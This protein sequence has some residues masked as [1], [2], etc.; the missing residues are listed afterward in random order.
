MPPEEV[1][2]D[3]VWYLPQFPV[4]RPDNATTKTRIIFDASA[5]F[6]DDSVIDV[7]LQGPKLQNDLF[8]VLLRF[9]R[10][11][12]IALMCDIKEMH[13]QINLK[14]EDQPYHRFLWRNVETDRESDAFEFELLFKHSLWL[15]NMPGGDTSPYFPLKLKQF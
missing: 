1:K 3:Q 6:N 4:L 12:A 2:P 11:P 7:V 5:K 13:L 14:S 9:R 8:E 10:D 15:K